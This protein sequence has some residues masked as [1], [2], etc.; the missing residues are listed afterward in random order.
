LLSKPPP[1]AVVLSG[2]ASIA[3]FVT[4]KR[5][6]ILALFVGALVYSVLAIRTSSRAHKAR[7]LTVV[8]LVM[9]VVAAGLVW[10]WENLES[11]MEKDLYRGRVGSGRSDF[12]RIIVA[13]WYDGSVFS[14]LFGKGFY[15]VPETLDATSGDRIYAHSDWLEILH[16]MGLL[17]VMLFAFLQYCLLMVVRQALRQREPVAPALAMGYCVFA[18]RNVYSQCVV[19]TNASVYFALLLGYAAAQTSRWRLDEECRT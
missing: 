13:E 8:L 17:G 4:V 2:L 14:L 9:A 18:L 6:T 3:V 7:D 11:R 16:D 15:T 19:G 12:Y 5:G 10:Q 1:W